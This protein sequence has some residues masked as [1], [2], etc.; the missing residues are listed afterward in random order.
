VTGIAMDGV[1]HHV[2]S[3]IILHWRQHPQWRLWT[4]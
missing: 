4:L 2:I 3:L 1:E